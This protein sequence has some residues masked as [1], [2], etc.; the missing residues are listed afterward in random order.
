MPAK[1]VVDAVEARIG[2]TWNGIPVQGV[3]L[4]GDVPDD[5]SSFIVVQYPLANSR[6]LGLARHFMEEGIVRIVINGERG[7]GTGP[8]LE[9]QDDL[10][11]LF[12][13]RTFDGVETG[14]P[15]KSPLDDSNDLGS[16]YQLRLIVPYTYQY[17]DE[18]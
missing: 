2:S 10:A 4:K 3:N 14:T 12:R 5:A 11:T 15:D 16:F 9:W 8:L 1:A 18:G 17:S 13:D 7:R 6:R